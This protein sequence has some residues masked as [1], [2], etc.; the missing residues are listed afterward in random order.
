MCESL[1][2]CIADENNKVL[3]HSNTLKNNVR[4]LIPIH[5][6]CD[7]FKFFLVIFLIKID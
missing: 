2:L 4:A 1:V 3:L 5:F 6:L 7:I